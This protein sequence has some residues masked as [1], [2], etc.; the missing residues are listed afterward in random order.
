MTTVG[1]IANP[2]S[3][4]DI[5]RLV[6][7]SSVFDNNEK[8]SILRRVLIG[9]A[10]VGVDRVVFMPD[11]YGLGRAALEHLHLDLTVEFLEIEVHGDERDS[12]A[13]AR[14]FRDASSGRVGCIITL[15]GD[16]TVRAVAKACGAV[17]IVAISTGTNNVVPSMV[18]GT[19]A[20]MAAGLVATGAID[21]DA[22]TAT[23]KRL[24]VYRNEEL[25]DIALIDVVIST[26]LFVASRALWDPAQIREFFLA[27]AVP[28]SIGISSIGSAIR[29][30]T[31]EDDWG[32]YVQIGA[33]P[34]SVLAP[35]APGLVTRIGV[36][37]VRRIDVGEAIAVTPY[38]GTIALDGERAL[39][40][41]PDQNISVRLTR[42]GPR[43]VDIQACMQAATGASL[44]VET[45]EAE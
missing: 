13:A 23:I 35:V 1:I 11:Y 44:F 17:P 22:V 28:G 30:I 20:G 26:S 39:E 34:T 3:G 29:S 15:G 24:E 21:A 4:K 25:A 43:I 16:G 45:I 12:I 9:L 31:P 14:R 33:G 36:Q 2:A 42:D 6:A 7:H 10:A 41:F 38:A 27:E 8:V 37:H 32:L 19:I 40:V 18:E 5:R